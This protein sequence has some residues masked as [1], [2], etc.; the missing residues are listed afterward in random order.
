MNNLRDNPDFDQYYISR[1]IDLINT[2]FSPDSMLNLLDSLA[3][4]IFE[5]HFSKLLSGRV[6]EFARAC[7][8]R[9]I[10]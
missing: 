10:I 3:L 7:H 9:T 8:G 2:E 5:V 1:Y 6:N 4:I